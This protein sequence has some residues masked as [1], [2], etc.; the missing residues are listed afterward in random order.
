MPL[1]EQE[2][3]QVTDRHIDANLGLF[4][5]VFPSDFAILNNKDTSAAIS[6]ILTAVSFPTLNIIYSAAASLQ[7]V[8]RRNLKLLVRISEMEMRVKLEAYG[9]DGK[10]IVA[11]A[12]EAEPVQVLGIDPFKSK[13][14]RVVETE[15]GRF[16]QP[17]AEGNSLG[18]NP[19]LGK[20]APTLAKAAAG[21]IPIP[22]AGAVIGGAGELI[23]AVGP[24][25]G[26]NF[27]LF[28]EDKPKVRLPIVEMSTIASRQEFAWY[29]RALKA[30]DIPPDQQEIFIPDG[31]H[32]GSAFLQVRRDV[33][34]IK[35]RAVLAA[36]WNK[37][38]VN[39]IDEQVVEVPVFHPPLPKTPTLTRFT[40][41]D[42]MPLLAPRGD[43][44]RFLGVKPNELD[45]LVKDGQLKAFGEGADNITRASLLKL[46]GE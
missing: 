18:F 45:T 2:I 13:A 8:S 17:A 24:K 21:A 7:Q 44:E 37:N 14:I 46:L 1:N 5:M 35:V 28:G 11:E 15:D 32:Y 36:D 39:T 16:I 27:D 25:L 6:A 19:D 38:A 23:G 34:M 9:E 20:I 10:Q 33:R 41:P 29:L 22:G 43:V 31:T 26:L 40:N 30:D 12:D 3:R 42:V 4:G